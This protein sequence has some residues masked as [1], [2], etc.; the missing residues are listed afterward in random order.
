FPS[1]LSF[2]GLFI[3]IAGMVMHTFASRQTDQKTAEQTSANLTGS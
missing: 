2:A 3:I 1:L